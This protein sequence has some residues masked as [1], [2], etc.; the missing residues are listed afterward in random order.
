[1]H[2]ARRPRIS[3][4]VKG[5]GQIV[6]PLSSWP[7]A[8]PNEQVR[9]VC[10]SQPSDHPPHL[11]QEGIHHTTLTSVVLTISNVLDGDGAN[12]RPL[13]ANKC[14]SCVTNGSAGTEWD[15][16][17]VTTSPEQGGKPKRSIQKVS[18]G[19]GNLHVVLATESQVKGTESSFARARRTLRS[20]RGG[21]RWTPGRGVFARA[22]VAIGLSLAVQLGLK[23]MELN[24]PDYADVLRQHRQIV[25]ACV[26]ATVFGL[27]PDVSATSRLPHLRIDGRRGGAGLIVGLIIGWMA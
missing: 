16:P 13:A 9:T 22:L 17:C 18:S 26:W 21:G 8:D 6:D 23:Y 15:S 12:L 3:T 11:R 19:S 20:R 4:C 5:L 1:M 14:S 10:P 25:H 27:Y 7:I 24:F 2:A